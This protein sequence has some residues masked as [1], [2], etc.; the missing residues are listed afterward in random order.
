MAENQ[1]QD[2]WNQ[3]NSGL[4][5][6]K[7][8]N[9]KLIKDIIKIKYSNKMKSILKYESIGSIILLITLMVMII[10]IQKF[11]SLP[12]QVT[13]VIS[14]MLL[15]LLPILSVSSLF[16]MQSLDMSIRNCKENIIEFSKRQ[17]RFLLIQKWSVALTPIFLLAII[18]PFVKISKGEDF[19][20][21]ESNHILWYL[22]IALIAVLAF[23]KWS[24]A[25]YVHITNDAKKLL[26]ELDLEADE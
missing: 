16:Q 21:G 1:L 8:I 19:F 6:Q 12:L 3:L 13:A 17:A 11:D 14:I 25:C 23:A 7:I 20:A 5:K 24:Y 4:N 15:T 18:P 9:E 10:N 26:Q 22:P 2:I